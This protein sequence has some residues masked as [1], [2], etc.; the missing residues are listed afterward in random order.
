VS[1][2]VTDAKTALRTVFLVVHMGF[3]ARYLLRTDI[4]STLKA[5][6]VRIVILTPNPDEPYMAKEFSD[7]GVLLERLR[8]DWTDVSLVTA[9]RAWS[10]CFYLRKYTLAG[11]HRSEAL[12]E[13]YANFDAM[14]RAR[15]R[16]LAA[17]FRLALNGLW[18]S[19]ALRRLLLGIETRLFTRAVHD[20]L[21][22]RYEP[23]LVVTTSP[24]W[25]FPDAVV[26]REARAR[27][28]A[29]ATLVLSWDNPTS[30]GYRGAEPERTIV[31]SDEMARQIAEHHDYPRAQIRVEGVPHFDH[32]VR[33]GALLTREELCEQLGLDPA[34]RLILFATS[35]PGIFRR[36]AAVAETLAQAIATD[37]L[38]VPA[39]LV[40]RLHPINFRP[41]HRT[42][43]D[44][45]RRLVE[46]YPNVQLDVP[47][48]RSERLRVDMAASDGLRLGSLIKH[49]DVLVNVFSTTTLEA[50]LVDRPVVLVSSEVDLDRGVGGRRREFHEYE[51]VRSVMA[52]QAARVAY[53]LPEIVDHLRAYLADPSLDAEGRSRVAARELGPADGWSGQRI[54]GALL[55]LLG[56]SPA[57]KEPAIAPREEV[58]G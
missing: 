16:F 29:G 7:S 53:S 14:V 26:L 49:C 48:V 35:S 24:G 54:G 40:V 45:Y 13:K 5:A 23:H 3:A 58:P 11:G 36:N 50:F 31:W 2:S 27:G 9:S 46:A 20:D 8:V 18:R 22:D 56:V 41:D 55:A 12:Q 28:V 44:E 51:H 6:G 19:H 34:R 21:F 1:S 32:Y 39:Q 47:E 15:N 37:A 33:E 4:L 25:F 10:L 57:S 52:E 43:L 30:K 17:C 42:P 38:G